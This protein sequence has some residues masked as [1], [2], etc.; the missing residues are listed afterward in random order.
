MRLNNL[1][2]LADLSLAQRHFDEALRQAQAA[3]AYH[4][5]L[6]DLANES[7]TLGTLGLIHAHLG[8]TEE[9]YAHQQ[10]VGLVPRDFAV[11]YNVFPLGADTSTL[12]IAMS[13]PSN[14][15]VIDELRFRTGRRVKVCIGGDREVAAAIQAAYPSHDGAVEAI[16][17]DIDDLGEDS[18]PVL[19]GFGGGSSQDFDSFFGTEQGHEAELSDPFAA[20][21]AEAPVAVPES[22][23]DDAPEPVST[24][25]ADGAPLPTMPFPATA[26]VRPVRATAYVPCARPRRKRTQ[27]PKRTRSRFRL[28]STR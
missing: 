10:A 23:P 17:L 19:S 8:Q 25:Y 24:Q 11:K 2:H 26:S 5:S 27:R 20:G 3:L 9:A 13:D 12:S 6:G 15:S 16:A 4:R 21:P 28:G 7:T 22:L 1:Q 14:L 18:E